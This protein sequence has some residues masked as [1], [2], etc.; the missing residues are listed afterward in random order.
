MST[1]CQ[2]YLQVLVCDIQ[3]FLSWPLGSTISYPDRQRPCR[4]LSSGI[5][6][7]YRSMVVLPCVVVY[8]HRLLARYSDHS[9]RVSMVDSSVE[10]TPLQA[11]SGRTLH[12]DIVRVR[13]L[14]FCPLSALSIY[15]MYIAT[16]VQTERTD[17][18]FTIDSLRYENLATTTIEHHNGLATGSPFHAQRL[19]GQGRPEAAEYIT[20]A[21]VDQHERC[22][23]VNIPAVHCVA[24][25]VPGLAAAGTQVH[26]MVR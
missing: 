24:L 21:S 8:W 11:T 19:L 15:P 12:Q 5:N 6:E 10:A 20:G 3:N 4:S 13:P 23:D 14:R 9:I 7:L 2:G 17:F 16:A 25:L 1:C 22:L 18:S 26:P